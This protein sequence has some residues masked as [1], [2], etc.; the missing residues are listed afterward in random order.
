MLAFILIVCLL[1]MAQHSCVDCC[2]SPVTIPAPSKLLS[3]PEEP[4]GFDSS[5]SKQRQDGLIVENEDEEDLDGSDRSFGDLL[6]L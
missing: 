4:I 6:A 3:P 1:S 5:F 2:V